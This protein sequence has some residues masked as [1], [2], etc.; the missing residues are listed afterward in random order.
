MRKLAFI[1]FLSI[2]LSRILLL[3]SF[4]QDLKFSFTPAHHSHCDASPSLPSLS[5][6]SLVRF[7]SRHPEEA[8]LSLSFSSPPLIPACPWFA[9]FINW[10]ALSLSGTLFFICL[11]PSTSLC[12]NESAVGRF[13]I[14]LC[15]P[16]APSF[17][18]FFSLHATHLDFHYRLI[19]SRPFPCSSILHE[20]KENSF[21]SFSFPQSSLLYQA[22][23]LLLLLLFNI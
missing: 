13:S 9:P 20:Y 8:N 14:C 4:S 23:R 12:S 18:F 2:S 11:S 1:N 21:F 6:F 5:C 7:P 3:I 17:L 19:F 22:E 15:M 16:P 10:S